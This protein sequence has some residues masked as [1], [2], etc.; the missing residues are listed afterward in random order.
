MK[1]TV[2]TI[3]IS[4]AVIA[5]GFCIPSLRSAWTGDG[6]FVEGSSAACASHEVSGVRITA[7]IVPAP[8]AL[9]HNKP[10]V[11]SDQ[12]G[13]L[14]IQVRFSMIDEH[15]QGDVMMFGV[16]NEKGYQEQAYRLNFDWS[17]LAEIDCGGHHYAPVLASWENTYGLTKDRSVTL[18]FVPPNADDEY[19]YGSEDVRLTLYSP[20]N[21]IGDLHY[22]FSREAIKAVLS[23]TP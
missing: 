14:T 18:A 13:Q 12:A 17:E 6:G 8:S 19:F 3:I 2:I 16:H 9:D 10:E 11:H 21:G 5:C 23:P 1:P 22:T 20:L 7:W 4:G 15:A